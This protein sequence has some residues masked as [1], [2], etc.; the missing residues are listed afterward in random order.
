MKV[1][2][3]NS[4]LAVDTLEQYALLSE[5][6][7]PAHLLRYLLFYRTILLHFTQS[8]IP[9]DITFGLHA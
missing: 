4:T 5:V 7:G 1:L 2:K 8:A 9:Y 6:K 3:V